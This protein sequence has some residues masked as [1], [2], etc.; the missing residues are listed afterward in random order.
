MTTIATAAALLHAALQD[1]HA[2]EAD[3][4]D[5]LGGIAG[6][7]SDPALRSLLEE[8]A[9]RTARQAQRIVDAGIDTSGPA[10]LW[11]AGILDDA[12][13]DTRATQAGRLLDIA[14]IG[15]IRKGKA[16]EIV[17]SETAIALADEVD[18]PDLRAIASA[19][20]DEEMETDRRLR[21]RL[22]ALAG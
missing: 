19:N 12:E 21:E 3:Q 22:A 5:R 7:C 15:A 18:L 17:S 10:N 9:E 4:A 13:R 8:E 6:H 14:V 20:R 2:G 16:A 11:M 1:L